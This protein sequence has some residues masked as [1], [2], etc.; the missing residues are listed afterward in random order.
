[1]IFVPV[2]QE[3]N[4]FAKR[5]FKLPF[6]AIR[7]LKEGVCV[8]VCTSVRAFAKVSV[9]VGERRGTTMGLDAAE[10]SAHFYI[11]LSYSTIRF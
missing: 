8:C 5:S 10:I 7:L 1:M 2:R 3:V 6:S 11:V 4:I 9:G